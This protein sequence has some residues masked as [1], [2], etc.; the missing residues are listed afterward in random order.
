MDTAIEY[1]RLLP[2]QSALHLSPLENP[3]ADRTD[4]LRVEHRDPGS[5]LHVQRI[6]NQSAQPEHLLCVLHWGPAIPVDNDFREPTEVLLDQAK[7]SLN[8]LI[9]LLI[10]SLLL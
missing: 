5:L 10:I 7:R 9:Q 4:I 1:S 3:R 8:V 6:P 2:L